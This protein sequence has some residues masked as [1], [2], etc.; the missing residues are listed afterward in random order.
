MHYLTPLLI[1]LL[2]TCARAQEHEVLR[3]KTAVYQIRSTQ[4]STLAYAGNI[5]QGQPL[6]SLDWAWNSQNAC[7]VEPR[8]AEFTGNA[9][10]YRTDIPKYSTMVIRLIPDDPKEH[11]SLLAYSGGWGKLPPE[12]NGCVSCEADFQLDRPVRGRT[13]PAHIRSVELRAVNRPYPVTIG[14]FGADGRRQG[15]YRIEV[16]VKRNR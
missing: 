14:V 6:S 13:R 1:L 15:G 5:D 4:D 7:F 10:F 3:S 2:G 12:L 9:V 8:K 11:L 16:S